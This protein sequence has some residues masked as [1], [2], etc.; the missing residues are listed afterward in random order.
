MDW[1]TV[2]VVPH[3]HPTVAGMGTSNPGDSARNKAGR[4]DEWK[5]LEN[6]NMKAQN[7]TIATKKEERNQVV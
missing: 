7:Y 2:S 1:R 3:L 6:T 4:E 5:L